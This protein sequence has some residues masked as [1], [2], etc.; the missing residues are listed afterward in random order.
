MSEHGQLGL[1]ALRSGMHRNT[2]RRYVELGRLPSA[3]K[4]LRTWRTREDPFAEDWEEVAERLT[5]APELEAK[6]L[7]EYLMDR[8]PGRYQ[9][10]QVRTF[11]RRVK[12]WRAECGPPREIFFPQ[13]HRAGEAIQTDFTRAGELGVTLAGRAVRAPAVSVGASVQ[14]LAVGDG[15]PVGV[16]AGAASWDPDGVVSTGAES[17]SGTRPTTRPRRPT[18]FIDGQARFQRRVRGAD[19][20]LGDA[21]ADDRDRPEPP[22]RRCRGPGR[23]AEALR[24]SRDFESLEVYEGWIGEVVERANE[25]RS[26]RLA[27]EL[28][29][30]RPLSKRRLPEHREQWV[31]VTSNGTIRVLHNTYSVPSRLKGERVLVRIS[32]RTVEVLYGGRRQLVIERLLGEGR[33]RIDYRH[34]IESLVRKPWA[35][36]RYRHRES[37]FPTPVFRRAYDALAESL[38]ERPAEL[39]YL[40]V[41]HLAART[42]QCDVEAALEQILAASTDAGCR[43]T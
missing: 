6:A 28:A 12:Q 21:A 3:R 13:E 10:G 1:A 31:R 5:Q 35:F 8:H 11:Q 38:P 19:G 25:Q 14:Q 26:E 24:G 4:R 23:G 17:P 34:V 41:L 9:A 30:M 20:A 42:M 15:V 43:G 2:A 18:T 32:D 27:E 29:K 37:M 39:D 40:R 33:S 16:Y 22:E 36:A 7:F